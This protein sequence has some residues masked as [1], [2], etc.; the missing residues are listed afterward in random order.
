MSRIATIVVPLLLL[1]G[2]GCAPKRVSYLLVKA[3]PGVVLVPPGVAR[4]DLSKGTITT[5][6]PDRRA[7]CPN[8]GAALRASARGKRLTI[9][10]NRDALAAQ[11]QGWLWNWTAE[12]ERV[13]C[14]SPGTGLSVMSRVVEA[15]PLEPRVAHGLLRPEGKISWAEIGP[16]SRLQVVTPIMRDGAAPEAPLMETT[17]VSGSGTTINVD[18][19]A[20]DR[21][22]GY[23]MAWYGVVTKIDGP[24]FALA[25]LS[26]ERTLD[27]R[28]EPAPVSMAT[29]LR[30][31]PESRYY[32]L[33]LKAEVEGNSITQMVITAPTRA[34]LDRRTKAI[35]ADAALCGAPDG[36]CVAVP[37]RA[38]INVWLAVQVNGREVRVRG[39]T[40]R[41]AIQ[42]AGEKDVA[43]VMPTLAV[44]RPYRG[45]LARVEF[46]RASTEILEV[47]LL[48][49]E[50]I[51]W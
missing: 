18:V 8:G 30:F 1:L 27:G 25:P 38:A 40:V 17:A 41:G 42:A 49:G 15:V 43:R 39:G 50:R 37:R 24:G 29:Y 32:R 16:E 19:K 14:I 23:E 9:A 34:E 11:A 51:S 12:A 7:G 21:L 45:G 35:D 13:G 31:P 28:T 44:E 5:N 3:S 10:V 20:T 22:L 46:D 2:P 36:L 47:T 33:F 4:T 26:V 6:V 48:G